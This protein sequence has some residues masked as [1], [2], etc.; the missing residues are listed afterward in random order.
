[1][2]LPL[3]LLCP[4]SQLGTLPLDGRLELGGDGRVR[5]GGGL[6]LRLEML[7]LHFELPG[8]EQRVLVHDRLVLVLKPPLL[9]L[10]RR[11][12]HLPSRVAPRIRR[13][14]ARVAARVR[15]L[16]Q[17]AVDSVL[18]EAVHVTVRRV[19]PHALRAELHRKVV[20]GPLVVDHARAAAVPAAPDVATHE[21]DPEGGARA[22][23]LARGCRLLDAAGDVPADGAGRVVPLA[24]A[25]VVEGVVAEDGEDAGH[26]GVETL[27]ADSAER[28]LSRAAKLR[29]SAA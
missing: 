15:Q 3:H 22:A 4:P 25:V 1:M 19:V 29:A 23:D 17:L 13:A 27:E 16:D 28:Q 26:L 18:D 14:A 8:E 10:E 20:A 7:P 12:V 9:H 2:R 6:E 5:A 21:A 24:E 11:R